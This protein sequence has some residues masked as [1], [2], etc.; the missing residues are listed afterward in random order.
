MQKQC[1]DRTIW[2]GHLSAQTTIEVSCQ[3]QEEDCCNTPP[4]S[5]WCELNAHV[6]RK[7][8]GGHVFK[9]TRCKRQVRRDGKVPIIDRRS[10]LCSSLLTSFSSLST[11]QT[12]PQSVV[13]V[14]RSTTNMV[15]KSKERPHIYR[16]TK[17][18]LHRL[19]ILSISLNRSAQRPS[20]T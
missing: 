2:P 9:S 17:H 18:Y 10:R 7:G 14:S 5:R 19:I 6:L 16:H 3:P 8:L 11:K 15:L 1:L 20:S 4:P 13:L 12:E